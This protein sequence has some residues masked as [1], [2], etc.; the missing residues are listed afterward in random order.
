MGVRERLVDEVNIIRANEGASLFDIKDTLSQHISQTTL[1]SDLNTLRQLGVI[2]R[3]GDTTDYRR[4][5]YQ[6]RGGNDE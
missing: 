2:V 1:I 5:Y 3:K 4:V 6:I